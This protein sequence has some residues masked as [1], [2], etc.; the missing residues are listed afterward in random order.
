M[1]PVEENEQIEYL[2][3]FV[4]Q[5]IDMHLEFLRDSFHSGGQYRP[6]SN[7]CFLLFF[8]P[9]IPFLFPPLPPLYLASP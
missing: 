5:I 2:T 4:K 1:S 9:S 3:M 7:L 6:L 8:H